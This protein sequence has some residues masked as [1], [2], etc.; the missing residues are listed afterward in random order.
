RAEGRPGTGICDT[1]S[2]LHRGAACPG[3][4][5]GGDA[6]WVTGVTGSTGPW[7]LERVEPCSTLGTA[8]SCD[9]CAQNTGRGCGIDFACHV[10]RF[11]LCLGPRGPSNRWG[12]PACRVQ[13]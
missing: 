4:G 6:M 7:A 2:C 1:F 8:V 3:P 11:I 5:D 9:R 13:A 12:Q 10:S